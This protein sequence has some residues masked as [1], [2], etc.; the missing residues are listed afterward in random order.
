MQF[1]R[2][3]REKVTWYNYWQVARERDSA[4]CGRAGREKSG[5]TSGRTG[6]VLATRLCGGSRWKI[7]GHSGC[8][9]AERRLVS[10]ATGSTT[11]AHTYNTIHTNG[12]T[13][14]GVKRDCRRWLAC[15]GCSMRL[16]AAAYRAA[17]SLTDSKQPL[18][19]LPWGRVLGGESTW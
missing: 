10:C 6:E 5:R 4:G 13:Q 2:C 15:R 7:V 12:T 17:Y 19:M 3:A 14:T 16:V 18:F 1:V 8:W 9:S 11:I